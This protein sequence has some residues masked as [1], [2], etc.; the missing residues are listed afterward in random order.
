MKKEIYWLA[1]QPTPYN[2]FLYQHLRESTIF[3]F[4]FC[5]NLKQQNNLPF[6]VEKITFKDDY[7]FNKVLGIDFKILKEAIK[8]DT[9]FVMVGWEDIT[10]VTILALR[11]IL[12]LPYAFWTDSL[13]PKTT[14]KSKFYHFKKWLLSK[15]CVVFT[16]G[17]FGVAKMIES[18][19]YINQE[20]LVSL[21][22]FVELPSKFSLKKI[23]YPTEPLKIL[24]LARLMHGKGISNSIYAID[25]LKREG[26]NIQL[27]IG[28]IGPEKAN[29]EQLIYDLNLGDY[30]KL[31]GWLDTEKLKAERERSHLL[32]HAVD[33]HDPFPLVVLESMSYGLPIIGSSLAGSVCDRV[34]DGYN[35][36]ITD[37]PAPNHISTCI[38]KVINNNNLDKLSENARITAEKW[39]GEIGLEIVEN[40][41][42]CHCIK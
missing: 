15:A 40:A 32:L 22:F 41:L 30:V 31:L 25:I 12:G 9:I 7:F 18:G 35:G 21:P 37:S 11:R 4:R 24:L 34:I 3:N 14:K 36:Y 13:Q 17:N 2:Y 33:E 10:K 6:D 42:K 27:S 39:P 1:V 38:K 19:I 20:K 8:K 26:L 28:G 5:Y 23:N 29:Y 16:T